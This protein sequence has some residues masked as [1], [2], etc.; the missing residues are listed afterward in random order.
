[1]SSLYFKFHL[2]PLSFFFYTSPSP[3]PQKSSM[4]GVPILSLQGELKSYSDP[5]QNEAL[6][7][8]W[9]E[10][11]IK[12]LLKS[13]TKHFLSCLSTKNFSC[14]TYQTVYV[15]VS[16]CSY[17]VFTFMFQLFTILSSCRVSELSHYYSEMNPVRQKWIYTFFMYPFLSGERVAGKVLMCLTYRDG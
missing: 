5:L 6:V 17:V 13:I 1:M 2:S 11:K 8:M 10:V 7:Q 15:Y 3:H 4:T 16:A 9:M 14:A 12:P